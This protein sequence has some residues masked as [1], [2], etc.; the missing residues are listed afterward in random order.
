MPALVVAFW[1]AFGIM[2]CGLPFIVAEQ[3]RMFAGGDLAQLFVAAMFVSLAIYLLALAFRDVDLSVVAPFRYTY[4]LTSAVGGFLVFREVPDVWT[5][6]GAVLIVG[7]G[8][9]ALHREKV[10]RR[11]L[12]AEASTAL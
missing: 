8:I 12:T 4:L 1:G 6:A 10:R 2:L 3:W 7:S 9:Y 11:D 5:V